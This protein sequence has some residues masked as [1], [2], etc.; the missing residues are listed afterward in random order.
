MIVDHRQ[1]F[2]LKI[3]LENRNR[4]TRRV[5]RNCGIGNRNYLLLWPIA[6]G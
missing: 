3:S 2:T 4:Q 1:C 5:F 6:Y